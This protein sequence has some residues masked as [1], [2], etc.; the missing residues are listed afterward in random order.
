MYKVHEL[1][2]EWLEHKNQIKRMLAKKSLRECGENLLDWRRLNFLSSYLIIELKHG[3]FIDSQIVR[4]FLRPFTKCITKLW[5]TRYHEGCLRILRNTEN[6][7]GT[8][9]KWTNAKTEEFMYYYG[10]MPY[11]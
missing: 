2:K 1:V 5:I 10:R 8:K 3:Y 4:S 9:Y 7:D 6:L 11:N